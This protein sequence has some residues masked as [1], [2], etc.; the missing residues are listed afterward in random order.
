MRNPRLTIPGD[1]YHLI[2]R[3]IE[4]EWFLSS[5]D[6]RS[7]YLEL[8]GKALA[9]THWR[10]LGYALMSNHVHLLMV[11][12]R[13]P[14]ESMLK[15]THAPFAA[16]LNHR[17]ERIGPVF[18]SRP[19]MWRVRPP[20]VARTLAYIHNNPVR[21]GVVAAARDSDWT[22]HRAYLRGRGEDWLAF[23]EGLTRCDFHDGVAFDAWIDGEL[24]VPR[25][26]RV[27]SELRPIRARAHVRGAIELATPDAGK[28]TSVALVRRPYGHVRANPRRFVVWLARFCGVPANVLRSRGRSSELVRAKRLAIHVGRALGLSITQVT[29]ALGIS[30]QAGSKLASCA[31]EVDESGIAAIAKRYLA[32]KL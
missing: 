31:A 9:F 12:G 24:R 22:S 16:W 2:S 18:A 20:D 27:D 3:F 23:A 13:D 11:A 14:A 1:V 21:A 26:K 8:F 7:R 10:C 25:L 17:R 5:T 29:D 4:R 15:R 30:A 32:N 6:E 28:L 19:A